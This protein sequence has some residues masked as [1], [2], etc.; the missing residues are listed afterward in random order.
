M[1]VYDGHGNETVSPRRETGK[2]PCCEESPDGV[3]NQHLD[4]YM[5][6]LTYDKGVQFVTPSDY[7]RA[8]NRAAARLA[9]EMEKPV[10]EVP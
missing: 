7:W 1:R 8:R 6:W 9:R 3:C 2:L 5:T 4:A 10:R